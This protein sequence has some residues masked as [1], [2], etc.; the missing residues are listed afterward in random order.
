MHPYVD[1]S[2][3]YNSQDMEKTSVSMDRWMDK[4]EIFM[5]FT[6]LTFQC[7]TDF[8]GCPHSLGFD[9]KDGIYHCYNI[10][11]CMQ[12]SLFFQN[13]SSKSLNEILFT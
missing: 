6:S 11:D 4:K 2:I 9:T 5:N 1:H 7:I 8:H 13:F 12:S 10:D 3:I